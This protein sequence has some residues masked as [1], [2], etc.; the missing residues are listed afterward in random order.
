MEFPKISDLP[1][2]HFVIQL[3][4]AFVVSVGGQL[5]VSLSTTFLNVLTMMLGNCCCWFSNSVSFTT[6]FN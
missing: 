6:D 4:I 3:G 2:M 5:V 1:N